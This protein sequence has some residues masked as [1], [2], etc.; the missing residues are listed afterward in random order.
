MKGR[1]SREV[2]LTNY[3][4][5]LAAFE[6]TAGMRESA[7]PASPVCHAPCRPGV[8]SARFKST[9]DYG[10]QARATV[11]S[12]SPPVAVCTEPRAADRYPRA[13]CCSWAGV[14][15]RAGLVMLNILTLPPLSPF[16]LSA[17]SPPSPVSLI[18][19]PKPFALPVTVSLPFSLLT[20]TADS[21][22]R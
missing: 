17:I 21:L 18:L 8:C 1:E 20:I 2:D 4:L 19:N 11:S 14:F 15:I 22:Q 13:C 16:S 3:F 5:V 12:P 7:R 6:V 10:R 9:C